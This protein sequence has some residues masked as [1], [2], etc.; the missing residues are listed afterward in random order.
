MPKKKFKET[1]VGAFLKEKAPKILDGIGDILPDNG[2]FGMVK[3][4]ISSDD[5]IG[6]E[7]KEMALKLLEQDIAEMNNVSS[8]WSSDMKSDS[9]LSKNTRP[10]TLIYLTIVMSLLIVLDSTVLLT[11][12]DGWVLLMEALLITVYVAYFGSRGAE[13]ITKI[14]VIDTL[15]IARN[16]FPGSS[17]SLDALCK[18]FKIDNSRRIK[19]TALID[20]DLLSKVYINLIDQREPIFQFKKELDNKELS[21]ENSESYSKKIIKP[22]ND[23]LEKHKKFIKDNFKRNFF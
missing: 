16:K 11:I 18:R 13:K 20:C 23:E 1:K 2:A 22:S 15:E 3:N 8:R 6:P 21:L 9:W 12:K 14:N 10:L 7:D 4:L 17:I 19:H 5:S